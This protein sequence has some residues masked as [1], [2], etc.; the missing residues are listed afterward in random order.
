MCFQ[1]SDAVSLDLLTYADLELLK[2]QKAG[3]RTNTD[4]GTNSVVAAPGS[5]KYLIV[6]YTAEFDRS[7]DLGT[8]RFSYV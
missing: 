4:P 2:T 5:K 6:T 8:L 3:T 1:A 7:V